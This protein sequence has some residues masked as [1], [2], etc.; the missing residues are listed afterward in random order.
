MVYLVLIAN[1]LLLVTGQVLWKMA[2][3]NI[4]AWSLQAA[5][6]LVLSPLFIGGAA[7]YVVATGLWLYVLSKLPLSVAYPSQSMSYILAAVLAL[8]LFRET[9]Q[10][11]QWVGM[12]VIMF[13]VYL[14]AK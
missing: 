9:V 14:V 3:S 1:I 5:L 7:L 10:P 2:V 13:G 8:V 11:M 12:L 6:R 4:D